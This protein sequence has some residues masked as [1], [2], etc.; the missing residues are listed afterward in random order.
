MESNIECQSC[1]IY[2]DLVRGEY[3]S[4]HEDPY[5]TKHYCSFTCMIRGLLHRI[6]EEIVYAED[7]RY[8]DIGEKLIE[9][10]DA[11]LSLG[12]VGFY[13]EDLEELKEILLPK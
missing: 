8:R 9:L 13:Q 7:Q 2:L 4:L 5:I 1:G 12:H 3:A 6:K 11:L 10:I